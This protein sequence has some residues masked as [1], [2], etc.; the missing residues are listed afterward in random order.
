[1]EKGSQQTWTFKIHAQIIDHH[2]NISHWSVWFLGAN[3]FIPG[4]GSM[5]MQ[6][7]YSALRGHLVSKAG[8][9]SLEPSHFNTCRNSSVSSAAAVHHTLQ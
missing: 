5:Y 1:M 2:L 3:F 7:T 9:L 4:Y 6:Y 8:H